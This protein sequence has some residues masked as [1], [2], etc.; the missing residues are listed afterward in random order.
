MNIIK[1]VLNREEIED[2]YKKKGLGDKDARSTLITSNIRLVYHIANKYKNLGI[3]VDDLIGIGIIGLIKGIDTFDLGKGTTLGTYVG[4]CIKNEIIMSLRKKVSFINIISL[5]EEID[6]NGDIDKAIHYEQIIGND[7]MDPHKEY[8]EVERKAKIKELLLKLDS[9]ERKIILLRYGFIRGKIFTQEEIGIN[10]G[11]TRSAI[12]RK[13][14]KILTKIRK[15][16]KVDQ[17]REYL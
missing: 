1:R 7:M 2:L 17:L 15:E 12:S 9:K 13:E 4:K 8:S 5:N 6:K 3:E 16:N 10:M 11:F 14:A